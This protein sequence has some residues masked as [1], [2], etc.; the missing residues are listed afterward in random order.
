MFSRD[1]LYHLMLSSLRVPSLQERPGDVPLLADH[2][3]KLEAKAA[4]KNLSGFSP[5]LLKALEGYDFPDNVRE[6]RNIIAKAV[7]DERGEVLTIDSIP[8]HMRES[9]SRPRGDK[10][11]GF[12]PR[13]LDE[14]AREHALL[15][16][17]HFKGDRAEAA[18]ALGVSG[19]ALEDLLGKKDA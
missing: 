2:F 7:A 14:V 3:L 15:T 13:A 1:L 18:R 6:L 12:R 19:Q 16:L 8:P 9:L 5:E 17:E 4:G 10:A 11:R